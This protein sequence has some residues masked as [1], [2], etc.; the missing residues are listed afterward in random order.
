MQQ[1]QLDQVSSLYRD[2]RPILEQLEL[3]DDR[4][5]QWRNR[6]LNWDGNIHLNS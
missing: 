3:T 1:I 2:F 6:L 5:H 4:A